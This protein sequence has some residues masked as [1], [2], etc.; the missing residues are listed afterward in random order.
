MVPAVPSDPRPVAAAGLFGA[1]RGW[2]RVIE[3][4]M[5]HAATQAALLKNEMVALV[6]LQAFGIYLTS[7]SE[8]RGCGTKDSM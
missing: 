3:S 5:L 2:A 6:F 8:P 7:N 4:V 1:A